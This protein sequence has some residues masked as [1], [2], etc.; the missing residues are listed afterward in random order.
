MMMRV[1]NVQDEEETEPQLPV[2]TEFDGLEL[3]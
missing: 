2:V 3:D 1:M